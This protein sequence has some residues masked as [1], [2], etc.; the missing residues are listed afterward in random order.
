LGSADIDPIKV[1]GCPPESPSGTI[2]LAEVLAKLAD[3][4]PRLQ[5]ALDRPARPEPLAYRKAD[6]ASMC[7]MSVRLW[8]RLLAAGKGP[9]P[10]AFAGRCPLWK[11][12]TLEAWISRGGSR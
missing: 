10:D 3:T 6:A 5:A 7:G 9:K 2:T 12:S 4:L 8:E 1:P 11:R